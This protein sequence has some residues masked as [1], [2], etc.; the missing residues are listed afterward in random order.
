MDNKRIIFSSEKKPINLN[1][2]NKIKI[3]EEPP[4]NNRYLRTFNKI[5]EQKEEKR[6][7]KIKKNVYDIFKKNGYKRIKIEEIFQH[8]F[9]IKYINMIYMQVNEKKGKNLK[10]ALCD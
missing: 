6:K 3:S 5:H 4:Y 7:I 2:E 1:S 9:M 8:P 10:L